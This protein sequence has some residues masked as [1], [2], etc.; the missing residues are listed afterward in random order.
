MSMMVNKGPGE[1]SSRFFDS[2]RAILFYIVEFPERL[3]HRNE[4]ELLFP[5]VAT[6]AA[7]TREAI[8]KVDLDHA[9]G[10]SA[11]KELQHLLLGWE[12]MGEPRRQGFVD[13]FAQYLSLY[14][15]HMT[16]E[17]TIILQAARQVLTPADWAELD[18][19]FQSN[20]DALTGTH[21]VDAAY[22]QLFSRIAHI[23]PAHLGVC[24]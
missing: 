2:L 22:E 17:E 8:A 18:T 14:R 24:F 19:A 10:E 1:E 6:R 20:R 4:T 23:A 9:K 11:V 5:L 7:Q 21:P 12:F 16:L 3:H 15:E 13:V